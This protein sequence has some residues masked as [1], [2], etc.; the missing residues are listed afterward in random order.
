MPQ[1][2]RREQ[3]IA[4]AGATGTATVTV[5]SKHPQD[6]E[7][8]V[9]EKYTQR[10]TYQSMTVDEEHWRSKGRHYVV[11]GNSKPTNGN[12]RAPIAGGYAL[13]RGIPA[14]FWDEWCKQNEGSPLLKPD[15]FD[16]Q[17]I[18]HALERPREVAA[19]AKDHAFVRS[20][21]EPMSPE[22]DPRNP[23]NPYGIKVKPDEDG[24][25]EFFFDE[26]GEEIADKAAR[27][28]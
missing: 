4:H 2:A 8:R 24:G 27:Q 1:A 15:G 6:I 20:N 7:L 25:N 14:E 21:M 18:L 23:K 19:W 22:D 13:T 26:E 9:M 10:V 17:P 16:G 3:S 11:K 5:A 28:A 12:Y